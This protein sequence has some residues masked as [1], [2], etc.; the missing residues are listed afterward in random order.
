[1]AGEI[2]YIKIERRVRVESKEVNLGDIASLECKNKN[3]LNRLKTLK[4]LQLDTNKTRQEVV[5]IMKVISL[6]HKVVPDLQVENQGEK[7]FIL[8]YGEQNQKNEIKKWLKTIFITLI[9]FFGAM[10]TIMT[11]HND[12]N[13]TGVFK[14]I[15]FLVMNKKPDGFSVLEISYSIGLA[16]GIIVF[17]NHLGGKFLTSDPTPMQVEMKTYEEEVDKTIIEEKNRKGIDIDVD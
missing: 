7:D 2:L 13:L 1:M 8:Y 16:V 9:V 14:N 5:S 10:F 11:F 4:V 12:V 15:Y 17:F 3:I 6:I